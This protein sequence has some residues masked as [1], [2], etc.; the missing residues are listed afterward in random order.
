ML[1]FLYFPWLIIARN[2]TARQAAGRK[3]GITRRIS[4][5]FF[6]KSLAVAAKS[7]K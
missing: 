3:I 4:A 6:A 2:F 1:L 7:F 5:Y